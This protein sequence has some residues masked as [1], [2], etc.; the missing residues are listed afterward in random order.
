MIEYMPSLMLPPLVF[1]EYYF[2]TAS[3]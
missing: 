1:F 2:T 3:V